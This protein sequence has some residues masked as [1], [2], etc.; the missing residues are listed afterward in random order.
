MKKLVLKKSGGARWCLSLS[1]VHFHAYMLHLCLII[2]FLVL[3]GVKKI[4]FLVLYNVKTM[5]L[6]I[7]FTV[8]SVNCENCV[9]GPS[10]LHS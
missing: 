2:D 1:A 9:P 5:S 6:T 7:Q 8:H 10:D 3:C 4:H